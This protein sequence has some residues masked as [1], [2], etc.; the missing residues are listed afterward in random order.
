MFFKMVSSLFLIF[1]MISGA[2]G[3]QWSVEYSNK[4]ACAVKG[5]T[6][7]MEATYTHP[8]DVTVIK[9]FW[10]INPVKGV[11]PTDLRNESGYSGRVEYLGDE[12]NPFSLRLSDV[13]KSD[14]NMYCFRFITTGK[15]YIGFP[16]IILRV[17]DRPKNVSISLSGEIVEGS[18][19]T[20][21]CSCDANPPVET[22][23]WFKRRT[24]VGKEKTFTISKVSV[25]DSGEYK[26]MCSN[27]VGHQNSTS[28]TLNVLYP[29]KNIS[30]S[31]SSSGE[32]VEGGLVNLTCSS[33]SNPPVETY[34]WFKENESSPVGSGQSYRALQS[35]LYYCEVQNKLGSER[36]AAV[37][38]TI[39]EVTEGESVILTC[40]TTCSLTDPTFIWYKNTHDLT[41]NTFKSNKL[42]LQRVS[43]KDAGSYNCA[44]RGSEHLPSPAQ[45]LSVRYPPKN[46]SISPSGEIV[47][48]SSVTLTCCSDANPPVETYTWFKE[49]EASPV[50]SGQSY[51]ALQSGLYYCEVQNKLGSERS[52]AVSITINDLRVI[53]PAE[54]TEGESVILTCNTTC[55][56]TDPTFIWYKNTH[57]LTTNTFKSNELHLQRVSSEDA[58]SYNCA[59]RG[60]EH[61]PSPA[62]YLSVRYFPKN[63][64]VSISPSGEI[65]EGSSVTL[66]CSSDANPPVETYTWLMGT[67]SVG[68]GKT[69]TI[70]KISSEDSGKYKCMCSNKVGHQ[71]STSVTLNVLCEKN[72]AGYFRII[73][74]ED[75]VDGEIFDYL[76]T[77]AGDRR[78]RQMKVIIRSSAEPDHVLHPSSLQN[79]GLSAK[80]DT[81]AA[82]D[83]A[84]RKSDDV[85]QTLAISHPTPAD[86]ETSSD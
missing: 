28:V 17:T 40:K 65:V 49:N 5:S 32:K 10:V 41:T 4:Q 62:Q 1:L 44:V 8:T 15:G 34:T 36:S 29:P 21:T 86:V 13:K 79:I 57:D 42:H 82:L 24:S 64:S 2:L 9:R 50:G 59:V 75:A 11:E 45:Y 16:G 33:D 66:T 76:C 46:V 23:T 31:I 61:L 52:A 6:V 69:I 84:D 7:V 48:G 22:Y 77:D 80:D 39:T 30:V 81:Y 55:S 54:V 38:I 37:S 43:S 18:S 35:G 63:I 27:K 67:T 26:C 73:F 19:V 51:R 83:P 78:K 53:A 3:N 25:E 68:K 60:S 56:L 12:Q 70:S 20:L 74:S 71:N 58:G 14:E 47:E 72:C 85:Y